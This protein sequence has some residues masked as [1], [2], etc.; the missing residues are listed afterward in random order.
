MKL[1]VTGRDGQLARSL[2]ER[3]AVRGGIELLLAG[4]PETD[5]AVP[6]TF[7]AAILSQ[8]PD[9]VINA[10][11]YTAV[12]S[13]EEEPAFVFRINAEAAREGAEA[14]AQTGA[15]FIQLSTDYV[16]DG[17]GTAAW[18]E[19]DPVRPLNVYGRSKAEGERLVQAAS[20]D[21]LVV[22]TSWLVSPFGKNFLKT[23][24]QRASTQDEVAVV[25]DQRGSLTSALDLADSLLKLALDGRAS[26]ILHLAGTGAA[27]WADVAEQ[28]FDACAALGGPTATVLRISSSHYTAG[29]VRPTNSVLDCSK[30]RDA[31]AVVLPDW[32]LATATIID[33][34]LDERRYGS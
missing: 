22:R 29:A 5:L 1:L 10:A 24:L 15:R 12:D 18:C 3:A 32:H 4:R 33:R 23:M 2:A 6:G 19:D 17:S 31:L 20:A 34:L 7:A 28:V 8:R 26:G 25:A 13:A 11:A 30:A 9:V 21:H 14:A 27:T 16:F